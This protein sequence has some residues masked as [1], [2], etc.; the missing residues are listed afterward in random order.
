[1]MKN[2]PSMCNDLVLKEPTRR[3]I[4]TIIPPNYSSWQTIELTH[5]CCKYVIKEGI[6][7]AFV[8]C[9]VAAGN[10]FAAMCLA[11]RHGFGFDSFQGIPWAGVNDTEQPGIGSKDL[12]KQ[13]IL[14][15]SGIM[16]HHIWHVIND[17]VK[18][19]IK[20]YSLIKGWFQDT[21]PKWM[22]SI[23]V[24][25]LDGDLYDSTF[26]PLKYLY[27]QLNDGGILII[28][29]WQLDGC[30][31]AFENFFDYVSQEGRPRLVY[32]NGVTYWQK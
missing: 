17:M 31:K 15:S 22:G 21:C 6:D 27:G 23:S 7:G 5:E 29:D 26:V 18:Y 1:M 10:N 12:S 30:R 16:V 3:D 28:D 2:Y 20:N 25:R 9:G 24:L 8:E 13:G 19:N 4:S 32:D 11:G 14:E